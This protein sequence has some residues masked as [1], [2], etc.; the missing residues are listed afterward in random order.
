MCCAL[1]LKLM[2]KRRTKQK[3]HIIRVLTFFSADRQSPGPP[4]L[5]RSHHR[6]ATSWVTRLEEERSRQGPAAAAHLFSL[7][8]QTFNPFS[9]HCSHLLPPNCGPV[10]GS[11]GRRSEHVEG[12]EVGQRFLLLALR[13]PPKQN[14]LV[15]R[16]LSRSILLCNQNKHF[17]CVSVAIGLFLS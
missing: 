10:I 4:W 13:V 3:V 16:W 9:S 6:V 14:N 7:A 17:V 8:P 2:E 15:A 11:Y 1:V 12:D 5:L